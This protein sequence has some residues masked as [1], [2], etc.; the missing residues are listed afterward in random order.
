MLTGRGGSLAGVGVDLKVIHLII[1]NDND[2]SLSHITGVGVELLTNPLVDG[3]KGVCRKGILGGRGLLEGLEEEMSICIA[4][5]HQDMRNKSN[6][7]IIFLLLP[8]IMNVALSKR[9]KI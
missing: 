8:D 1:I 7:K 4:P 5:I 2:R 3:V 9:V 6:R